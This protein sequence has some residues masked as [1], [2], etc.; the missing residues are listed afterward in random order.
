MESKGFKNPK[1]RG[2]AAEKVRQQ[3]MCIGA[4]VR[5]EKLIFLKE[6]KIRFSG[7]HIQ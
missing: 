6:A 1:R 7:H 3:S 5:G 4:I 2:D